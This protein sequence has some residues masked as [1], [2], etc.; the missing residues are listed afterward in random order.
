MTTKKL[1]WFMLQACRSEE[2]GDWDVNFIAE[3][4]TMKSLVL[5]LER[6]GGM[7]RGGSDRYTSG[8]GSE[9]FR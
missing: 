2:D 7:P 6:S 1:S 8:R 4:L 5:F 3:D 9:G